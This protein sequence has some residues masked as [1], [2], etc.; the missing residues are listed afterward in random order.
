M[1]PKMK[2]KFVQLWV[3]SPE[4]K[5]PYPYS[6]GQKMLDNRLSASKLEAEARAYCRA[7]RRR[8]PEICGYSIGAFDKQCWNT[9]SVA[10]FQAIGA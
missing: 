3:G 7:I 6:H 2:F 4:S 8:H 5:T 1:E 10:G 9:E